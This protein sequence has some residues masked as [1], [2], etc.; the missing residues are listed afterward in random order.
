ME[1]AM[2]R[3]PNWRARFSAYQI[4]CAS[5]PFRRG[6]HDCALYVARGAEALTGRDFLKDFSEPYDDLR[7]AVKR[8][9]SFGAGDLEDT[10]AA[11]APKLGLD[12][13]PRV[14]DVAIVQ[15]PGGK[16]TGFF[17]ET[18]ISLVGPQG[19]VFTARDAAVSAYKVG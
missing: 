15:R 14:G 3:L 10:I 11:F 2:T 4:A 18:G 8:L 9:R 13:P 7:S 1:E 19:L 6:R 12:E 17:T 16:V 5:K